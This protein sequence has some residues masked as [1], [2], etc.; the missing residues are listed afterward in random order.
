MTRRY[1]LAN[2]GA[3]KGWGPYSAR[4]AWGT[5]REDYSSY[6]NAWESYRTITPARGL[7]AGM[8]TDWPESATPA[9]RCFAPALWNERDPILKE[10]LSV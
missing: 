10:R 5:V 3:R 1:A 6:G 8:K 9:D 2:R 4:C 7:T